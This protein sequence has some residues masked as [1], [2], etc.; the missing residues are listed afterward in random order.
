MKEKHI[1]DARVLFGHKTKVKAMTFNT[2]YL[3]TRFPKLVFVKFWTF[4][5][6]RE[7]TIY[8]DTNHKHV[9]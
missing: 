4:F 5:V 9:F 3:E 1:L 7:T 6:I 2:K 8:L